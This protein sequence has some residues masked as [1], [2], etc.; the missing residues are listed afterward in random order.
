AEIHGGS[1]VLLGWHVQGPIPR[2]AGTAVAKIIAERSL[3]TGEMPAPGWRIVLSTGI[4]ARVALGHGKA[5]TVWLAYSEA[6][7]SESTKVEF[8]TTGSGPA[9]IWLNGKAVY[10]RDRPAVPGPYPERFEATLTTGTN[11]ILVRLAGS[12]SPGEFQL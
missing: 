11:R 6:V 3:P 7:V 4:D 9:T 12:T 8:F 1:G 5:D 2:A 10:Q